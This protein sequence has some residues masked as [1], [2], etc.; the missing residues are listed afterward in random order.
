MHWKGQADPFAVARAA[1]LL[2]PL[3]GNPVDVADVAHNHGRQIATNRMSLATLFFYCVAT[4]V[5]H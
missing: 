5:H 4:E 3:L 1:F 2:I